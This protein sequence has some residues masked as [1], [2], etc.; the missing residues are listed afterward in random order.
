MLDGILES[1][2][3]VMVA[4]DT[5]LHTSLLA[6]ALRAQKR[7]QEAHDVEAAPYMR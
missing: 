5:R 2:I 4:D 1:A 7:N 6:D 3:R